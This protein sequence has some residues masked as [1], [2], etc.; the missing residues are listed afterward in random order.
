MK[1]NSSP[2]R[3]VVLGGGFGGLAF[4]KELSDP[5]FSITLIDRQ[6]HH[7]FQPLL[8]Q[9]ATGG[10]S[11]PEIAQPIR[12]IL[13]KQ[14]NV[15]VL[16]EE[17][18]SID[19]AGRVVQ[20]EGRALGYDYLVIALGARTGYF[21]HNEWEEHAPGLKTLEDA[22]RIRTEVLGC[23]EAAESATDPALRAKLLTTVVVGGGPTGVE[24]AGSLAELSRK[25]LARDFR[26][27]RPD[28]AKVYLIEGGPR[29]LSTFA[30]ELS[31][32][33][34]ERL[35]KMGVT[36]KV[37]TTVQ[38]ISAGEVTLAGETLHAA[39]IVW[40]AGVEAVPLT[41]TLGVPVDR[42]GRIQVNPDLSLP[43]HAEVFAIGDLVALTDV[44]GQRVPGV[45]PA[46]MQMGRHVA[47]LL[48]NEANHQEK[49]V[50]PMTRPGFAYFDKGSMAT[51][52]RN[53]AVAETS[54]M[55]AKGFIAWMMWLFIHL[56]FLV[57]FR[58]R[59]F[60]FLQWVY[61]YFSWHR[62]ARIIT[63]K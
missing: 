57:G 10:L 35:E 5:R 45:S 54:F 46:A 6:N 43:G 12:A 42:G 7:L 11:A 23:Y 16:M 44:K 8:Y 53:A 62:G 49:Y 47:R 58:N 30:A 21:G 4:C 37:S 20:L 38:N 33:G 56:L 9:V 50:V 55:K 40:A 27:I 1:P 14:R 61:S 24:M 19:L 13:R 3:V 28:E 26:N 2:V 25:V 59:I 34:K 31:T 63:K 32:Y 48:R 15:T 39:T 60:V 36:V 52:G 17:V 22:R 29:V 18:K 41:R 51:I